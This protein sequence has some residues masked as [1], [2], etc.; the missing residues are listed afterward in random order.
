VLLRAGSGGSA[1]S[2][3]PALTVGETVLGR[4]FFIHEARARRDGQALRAYEFL[5]ATFGE[6]LGARAVE[7]ELADLV[8]DDLRQ[9]HR[10]RIAPTDD[11][12]LHALL[13]FS[14]LSQRRTTLDFLTDLLAGWDEQRLNVLRVI[15]LGLFRRALEPRERGRMADYAPVPLSVPARHAVY[16]ANLVLLLVAIGAP[17]TTD[18]LFPD[19]D[20][21]IDEWRRLTLLWKSQFRADA[22][23]RLVGT[24]GVQRGWVDERRVLVF[25]R[26]RSW[27][28][29]NAPASDLYWTRDVLTADKRDQEFVRGHFAWLQDNDRLRQWQTNLH[30]D[31]LDDL[32]HHALEPLATTIEDVVTVV[33]GYWDNRA[34]SA[35][36]SLITLWLRASVDSDPEELFDAFQVAAEVARRGFPPTGADARRTYRIILLRTLRDQRDRLGPTHTAALRKQLETRP[37]ADEPDKW[38]ELDALV[39][40]ILDGG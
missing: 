5:H 26:D 2:V 37:G 21:R 19:A 12:F 10:S 39:K 29:A 14:V 17:F 35:A 40:E 11:D 6:Y 7:R 33:H 20:D 9:S 32:A 1:T 27:P 31:P 36:Q 24:L 28:D 22:W 38:E 4:F 16:A 30:C 23:S 3:R 8:E 25:S 15:L 34:V 18:E 13:S